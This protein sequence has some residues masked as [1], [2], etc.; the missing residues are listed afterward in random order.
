L[1]QAWAGP[2]FAYMFNP[3]PQ[4]R[5]EKI[6][7]LLLTGVMREIS[8]LLQ[9]ATAFILVIE[10]ASDADHIRASLFIFIGSVG[11]IRGLAVFSVSFLPSARRRIAWCTQRIMPPTKSIA[12]CIRRSSSS[13]Q[14]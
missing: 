2:H 4:I 3:T 10:I 13:A 7:Y 12:H 8:V 14:Q 9:V 5:A 1:F 11:V 6:G